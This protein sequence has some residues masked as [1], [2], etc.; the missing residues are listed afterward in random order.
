VF[1]RKTSRRRFLGASAAACGFLAAP[2]VFSGFLEAGSPAERLLTGHIG[3]GGR[4]RAN[5]GRYAKRQAVALCDVDSR[6]L[7]QARRSIGE[8]PVGIFAD[9]RRLLDLK[10]VDAVIISTP[11]HWHALQSIHACR[12]G[13]HVYCEK[14]LTLAIAEGRAL[15]KAARENGR[16]VQ[17]GSQQRSAEEFRRACE[18]VRSGHLGKLSEVLVG[19]PGVNF[20][21]P[22]VPDGE[23]PPELDYELWL[24][25]APARPYNEKRVHYLFRFFWDYSGGQQTNWGA[26]HLD[27]A[28]WG[29]GA[30]ASGPLEVEGTARYHAEGWYEV[31]ESYELTYRYENGV[32]LRCGSRHPGGTTFIG[33]KG[34]IHAN[35]RK[36]SAEPAEILEISESD[37]SVRLP[38]SSDHFA[39]WERSIRDGKLPICDVEIGHRSATACHLG[40]IALR[41]GRK[42]R[43]DPVKEAVIGDEEAGAMVAKPGVVQNRVTPGFEPRLLFGGGGGPSPASAATRGLPLLGA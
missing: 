20:D 6:H 17:T 40:N 26:H 10:E 1:T 28:Q 29:L 33:E 4:G 2:S 15:V 21:G 27:I 35:R 9:Y 31:P 38:R 11:D 3:L 25:P 37:C 24:G 41:L 19:I 30:D 34:R 12:A 7:A 39:D 23:P 36:L 22:P 43:W 42:L 13:K 32:F 8:R 16:I 18:L 5:L 14:P